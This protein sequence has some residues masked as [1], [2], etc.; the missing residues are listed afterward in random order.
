[1]NS[2]QMRIFGFL[3]DEDLKQRNFTCISRLSRSK[4]FAFL[5]FFSFVCL[6]GDFIQFFMG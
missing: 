2:L 6:V 3:E 1:M 4:A 5:C